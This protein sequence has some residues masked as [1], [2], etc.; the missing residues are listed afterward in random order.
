MRIGLAR[1]FTE[2]GVPNPREGRV[3]T[4]TAVAR[5]C[6]SGQNLTERTVRL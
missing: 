2:R 1:A 3:W 6:T 4:H 5:L